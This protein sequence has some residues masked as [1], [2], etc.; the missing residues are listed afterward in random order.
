MKKV[1]YA[2]SFDP[3]TIGHLDVVQ[4]AAVRFDMVYV[5]L[6]VSERKTRTFDRKKMQ[7][8]IGDVL[9]AEKLDKKVKCISYDN[10]TG[11]TAIELGC[12]CLVRGIKNAHEFGYEEWLK[13]INLEKFG[14]NTL[15]ILPSCPELGRV[16]ST[17][18]KELFEARDMNG[19]K[20][21]LPPD[22][23]KIII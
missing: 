14:L 4:Q 23:F 16:S 21:L 15:F 5:G 18:A 13:N 10:Y 11:E 22:I 7:T 9:R 3:F 8:A 12:D 6:G 1:F 19:L 20:K 2:G 17:L